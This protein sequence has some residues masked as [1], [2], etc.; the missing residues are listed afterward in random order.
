V[1]LQP[2]A[3]AAFELDTYAYL[4]KLITQNDIACDWK[5]VGGVHPIKKSSKTLGS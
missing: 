4:D 3:V 2:A 1:Y 5:T